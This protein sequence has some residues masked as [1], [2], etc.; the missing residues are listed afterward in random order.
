MC[1]PYNNWVFGINN[2][3]LLVWLLARTSGVSPLQSVQNKS[4]WVWSILCNGYW[5]LFLQLKPVEMRGWRQP[6]HSVKIKNGLSYSSI[7]PYSF[8]TKE[9]SNSLNWTYFFL[10]IVLVIINIYQHINIKVLSYTALINMFR[11]WFCNFATRCRWN[12]S[13]SWNVAVSFLSPWHKGWPE[14]VQQYVSSFDRTSTC[15]GDVSISGTN[16]ISEG[17]KKRARVINFC[18]KLGRNSAGTF[19]LSKTAYGDD[20]VSRVRTF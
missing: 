2:W 19:E 13:L 9:S 5:R 20:C 15:T 8:M 7:L 17:K 6:S 16:K 12:A 4:L 11:H 3:D 1:S 18:I 10:C 14:W